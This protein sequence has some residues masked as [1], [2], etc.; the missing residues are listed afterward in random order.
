MTRRRT[1]R[2]VGCIDG[3]DALM[4]IVTSDPAQAVVFS[5]EVDQVVHKRLSGVVG[6]G[7]PFTHLVEPGDLD[8]S[9]TAH[10]FQ[11]WVG[12]DHEV[13]VTIV[14][15]V[16]FAVRIDARTPA[17]LVDWRADHERLTY[18]VIVLP[19]PIESALH[20]LMRRLRLRFAAVDFVVT[21]AGDWVFLELNAN[22]QWLWLEQHTGLPIAATVAAALGRAAGVASYRN[23]PPKGTTDRADHT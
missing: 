22:G 1:A 9:D 13:R 14:D 20:A 21:P 5:A 2:T 19:P 6:P 10:L 4:T 3:A 18:S 7:D 12:K 8:V 15:G 17:G 11:E 16:V 23:S